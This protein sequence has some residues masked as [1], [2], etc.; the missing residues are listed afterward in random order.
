VIFPSDLERF[1][2][3]G[4]AAQAAVDKAEENRLYEGRQ[5][6]IP[7]LP[8]APPPVQKPA[9]R[10]RSARFKLTGGRFDGQAEATVTIANG[11]FTV[12]PKG[13]RR[14]FEL[15]LADVARGVIFDV[16]KAERMEKLIARRARRRKGDR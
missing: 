16:V 3:G 5:H 7:G 4:Q 13:R 6:L 8:P 14:V 2:K 1:A 12:R 10:R 9:R 15:S 11:L